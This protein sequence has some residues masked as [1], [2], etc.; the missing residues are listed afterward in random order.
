MSLDSDQDL[1]ASLRERV[2]DAY[3]RNAPLNIVGGGSK[4]FYGRE[5]RGEP[6]EMGGHCGARFYE[7]TE[8]VLTARAGT[9]LAD[10][11]AMLAGQGQ[12]LGFE[13]PHCG[14]AATLGGAI[15]CGLSGPRRP[16]AGAARDFAL[17]AKLLNGKGEILSFGGQ[18]MKNVAGFDLS[19]L[20]VGAMGTLG[21][22]LE[23]SLKALPKPEAEITLAFE[24]D[25]ASALLAMNRLAG[26]K[27]P[28]SAACH[29]GA[30]LYL[31]LSG[32]EAA[33]A[34]SHRRLGGE[35]LMEGERFWADWREQRLPFF[36]GARRLWRL[37]LPS[38]APLAVLPGPCLMDWGGALRWL[39]TDA[40][41]A[42]IFEAARAAGGHAL[43]FRRRLPA[44]AAFQPLP[45]PLQRLH[46]RLKRA[47]DPKGILNPGRLY[48]EG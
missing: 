36:A 16:W 37:S 33:L 48:E 35:P 28:L 38:A 4:A 19:R 11:E 12:M 3:A 27:W 47:F 30:R 20:M 21:A 45:E 18:V 29:D 23:I 26:Q 46:I 14:A 8:L 1:S 24:R 44:E 17:G 7:P 10:I 42:Q 40:P 22:L 15:A 41:A 43:P 5:P 9:R 6:L 31:R 13:P 32:A 34:A 2:L 25:A 39:D